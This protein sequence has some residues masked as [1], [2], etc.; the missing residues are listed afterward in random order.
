M[1]TRPVSVR[2][3]DHILIV[4]ADRYGVGTP[5]GTL[6]SRALKEFT[7]KMDIPDSGYNVDE[8]TISEADMK[9]INAVEQ[10]KKEK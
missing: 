7:D 8:T 2:V 4:L 5:R 10:Q 9:A 3:S 6:V 1:S